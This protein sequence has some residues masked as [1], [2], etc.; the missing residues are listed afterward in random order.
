MNNYRLNYPDGI[1]AV[2]SKASSLAYII[3]IQNKTSTLCTQVSRSNYWSATSQFYEE[4]GTY[5]PAT[6]E[7][8]NLF[9]DRMRQGNIEVP[10]LQ[11]LEDYEIY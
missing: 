3:M 11:S 9:Y 8:K 1:Y 2:R 10:E 5:T 6:E 7:Q 4:W